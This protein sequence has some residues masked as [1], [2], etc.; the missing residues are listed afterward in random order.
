MP[1]AVS[2]ATLYFTTKKGPEWNQK[3]TQFGLKKGTEKVTSVVRKKDQEKNPIVQKFLKNI[4]KR[5]K[6]IAQNY[7]NFCKKHM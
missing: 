3:G 6:S 5:K 4:E 2:F 1:G 7:N